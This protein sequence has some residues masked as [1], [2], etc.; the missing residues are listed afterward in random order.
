MYSTIT[1][2]T[3][4]YVF[5]LQNINEERCLVDKL[6]GVVHVDKWF[7]YTT[8]EFIYLFITRDKNNEPW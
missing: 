2:Y 1:A 8:D 7:D 6:Y 3:F 4:R 5:S